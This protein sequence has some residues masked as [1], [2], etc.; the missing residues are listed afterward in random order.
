[1]GRIYKTKQAVD[2]DSFIHAK[3]D[4]KENYKTGNI[5][6]G[7]AEIKC[8][9]LDWEKH[10]CCGGK[11]KKWVKKS[12]RSRRITLVECECHAT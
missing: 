11:G 2:L 8:P 9:D 10:P 1:M 5:T 6:I 3:P 12:P 7:G 4:K